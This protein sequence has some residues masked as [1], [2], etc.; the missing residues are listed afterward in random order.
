MT[1]SAFLLLLGMSLL[2]IIVSLV[3]SRSRRRE[4]RSAK[5]SPTAAAG[6]VDRSADAAVPVRSEIWTS[7]VWNVIGVG[8]G[9]VGT[10][11]SA[12]ALIK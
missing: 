2:I 11:I 1:V 4:R 6:P 5:S 8:A 9:V 3:G 10:I 12:V 7:P